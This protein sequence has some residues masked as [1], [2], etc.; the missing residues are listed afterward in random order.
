L[1]E[2]RLAYEGAAQIADSQ[3]KNKLNA[4]ADEAILK[5]R[6]EEFEKELEQYKADEPARNKRREEKEKLIHL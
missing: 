5:Y 3:R 6:Q 1:N 4:Q 2:R